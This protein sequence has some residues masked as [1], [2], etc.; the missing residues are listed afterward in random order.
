MLVLWV[1]KLFLSGMRPLEEV[2]E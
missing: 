1:K 2:L